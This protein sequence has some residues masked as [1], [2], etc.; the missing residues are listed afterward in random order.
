MR[1]KQ[2]MLAK[3]RKYIDA[4]NLKRKADMLEAIEIDVCSLLSLCSLCSLCLPAVRYDPCP[5]CACIGPYRPF[6]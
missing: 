3:A 5:Y 2:V 4:E 1:K 6:S